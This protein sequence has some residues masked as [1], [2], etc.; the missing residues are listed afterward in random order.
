MVVVAVVVLVYNS[1]IGGGGN[2]YGGSRSSCDVVGVVVVPRMKTFT[3]Q[4]R[5]MKVMLAAKSLHI[6][7]NTACI[8]IYLYIQTPINAL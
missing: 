6:S 4:T 3:P 2:N 7:I 8:C 5:A 1:C